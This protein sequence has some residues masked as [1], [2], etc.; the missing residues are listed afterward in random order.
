VEPARETGGM[1]HRLSPRKNRPM[2]DREA[3]TRRGPAV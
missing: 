2:S 1:G 3:R